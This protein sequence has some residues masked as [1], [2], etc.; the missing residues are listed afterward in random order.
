MSDASKILLFLLVVFLAGYLLALNDASRKVKE[1]FQDVIVKPIEDEDPTQLVNRINDVYREVYGVSIPT[2][3]L[4]QLTS[5]YD[6]TTYSDEVYRKI[7]LND[8]KDDH[9]MNVKTTYA[10]VL[11]R[12][13]TPVELDKYTTMFQ[14]KRLTNLTQLQALLK[15]EPEAANKLLKPRA[16]LYDSNK[17]DYAVYQ[18]IVQVFENVLD[19]QPTVQEMNYYLKMMK[20]S[21]SFDENK[22]RLALASSREFGILSK[23]QQNNVQ[24]NLVGNITTRQLELIVN[25]IYT[26]VYN[27]PPDAIT[28][29]F[30]MSKLL[31]FNNDE[32]KLMMFL[33][34]MKQLEEAAMGTTTDIDALGTYDPMW[35]KSCLPSKQI[36]IN[37]ITSAPNMLPIVME[38]PAFDLGASMMAKPLLGQAGDALGIANPITLES[39]TQLKT[40]QAPTSETATLVEVPVQSGIENNG[41]PSLKVLKELDPV[42]IVYEDKPL[43]GSAIALIKQKA[44]M[45]F[46][47][48]AL[49]DALEATIGDDPY[50]NFQANRP[51]NQRNYDLLRQYEGISQNDPIWDERL[52]MFAPLAYQEKNDIITEAI[53][54]N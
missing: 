19:R 7:L 8:L 23:N 1:P 2:E 25:E 26:K 54:H 49:A 31:E 15:A 37:D 27:A 28:M 30:A 4:Q 32:Q 21:N 38:K 5:T 29:K 36:L 11:G 50:A 44:A 41:L 16:C 20:G 40:F 13:P 39:F 10:E 22:L 12:L 3:K 46:N 52:S 6:L 34:N 53:L 48:E 35:A 45:E 47:K 33:K 51:I 9:D 17:D 24:A 43:T 42:S 14:D 18:R